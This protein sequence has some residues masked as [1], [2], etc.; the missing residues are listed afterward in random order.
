MANDTPKKLPA[1]SN[2]HA[3]MHAEPV[4]L[5]FVLPGFKRATVGGLISPGGVGKSYWTLSVA[6][7]IA[8][9][10]VDLTGLKPATGKVVVLS[11]EDSEDI[12]TQRLQAM[13]TYLPSKLSLKDFDFRSCVGMNIDLMKEEWFAQVLEVAKDAR[14][15]VLDTLS[16]FHSL[17]E[18]A[19]PDMK[20][21]LAQ[22]ERLAQE[23][24]AAVLYLHHTSKSSVMSGQ[25]ATQQAARGS[26]VLVDN[27]RWASFLSVMTES[28]ARQFGVPAGERA[29]YVR[30]NIS[31]QNYGAPMA[32]QWYQRGVGGVLIP[33]TLTQ[34]KSQEVVVPAAGPAVAMAPTDNPSQPAGE[35][36]APVVLDPTKTATG[37]YDGKW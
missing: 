12:L 6:V 37:A 2:L 24:G 19:A 23:S 7:S 30:W 16:R 13:K 25:G 5:D 36:S 15:L 35:P 1:A 21:L 32:D 34:K 18:N 11:A 4:V 28:E 22:L 10:K 17:D 31:K 29:N 27:A 33:Y 3:L 9:G 14:L 8:A 20:A 26:S